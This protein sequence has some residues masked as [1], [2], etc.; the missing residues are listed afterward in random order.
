MLTDTRKLRER[1]AAAQARERT[2]R[3]D[4]ARLRREM[5]AL[6]RRRETQRLCTLGRAF[7]AWGAGD[8]RFRGAA[9]RFLAGYI[10]RPV[11]RE[12]FAG[13]PWEL[14]AAAVT[15]DPSAGEASHAG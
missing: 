12:V 3:A 13:T 2:A 10:S 9:V 11:D 7:E 5:L 15:A 6:D 4:A 1:L 8:E 14:P